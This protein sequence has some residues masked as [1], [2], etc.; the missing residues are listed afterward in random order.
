MK[1]LRYFLKESYINSRALVIGINKYKNV[2]PLA[3]AVND[4][5]EIKSLLINE[6]DFEESNISFLLD[7]NAT[8]ENILRAFSRLTRDDVELDERI[9]IFLCWTW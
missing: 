2:S 9:F 6:F 1:D 4:A 3:Y 8:K 5:L 7:E